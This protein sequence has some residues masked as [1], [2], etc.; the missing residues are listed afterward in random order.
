MTEI[1]LSLQSKI[2][3]AF[4]LIKNLDQK[5]EFS[6]DIT[7]IAE[8]NFYHQKIWSFLDSQSPFVHSFCLLSLLV[9]FEDIIF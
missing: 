7:V 2:S 5:I 6:P 3:Q 4:S 8:Y 9:R 1:F